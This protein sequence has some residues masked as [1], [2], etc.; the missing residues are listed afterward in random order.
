MQ[1]LTG[2]A[3]FL[4]LVGLLLAYFIYGYV[5]KQPNGNETMQK[6]EGMIHA[7]AMAFLKKEYSILA[8]FIVVVLVLLGLGINWQTAICFLTGALCSMVAGFSGMTAATRGNSRTAEA[9]NKFGQAK[10]LNV[11]YF[12][13]AV[14][15]LSVASLGLLGV[16]FWFYVYGGDPQTAQYINGFAMGASSIAL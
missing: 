10:A 16:G 6:I 4:A 7:G 13:G 14:M 12:S 2:V 3:P 8:I 1:S 11:S 15:G 5:K 9:A